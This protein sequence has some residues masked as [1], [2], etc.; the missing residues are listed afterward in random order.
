[1]GQGKHEGGRVFGWRRRTCRNSFTAP[2]TCVWLSAAVEKTWLFLVG[3]VVLR[4]IMR[5][6]TPPSVSMPSDSGV[7]SSSRM[8]FTSPRST[9][10]VEGQGR[11]FGRRYNHFSPPIHW[12]LKTCSR[13]DE[14]AYSFSCPFH[15][16]NLPHCLCHCS[17]SAPCNTHPGLPRPLPRLRRG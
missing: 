6:K 14:L 16:P 4:L 17:L 10:P 12:T 2:R 13:G 3:M 8:S 5:V 7:T 15:V 11:G 1:M 9:P